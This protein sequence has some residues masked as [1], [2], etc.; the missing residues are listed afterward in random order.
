LATLLFAG[1]NEPE[2]CAYDSHS[3]CSKQPAKAGTTQSR[4]HTFLGH[5]AIGFILRRGD[6]VKL[7]C[8]LW[9]ISEYGGKNPGDRFIP[10][11]GH[12]TAIHRSPY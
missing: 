3:G 2:V 12:R 10:D 7:E 11:S 6:R 8:P 1:D 9:V 4:R 5:S